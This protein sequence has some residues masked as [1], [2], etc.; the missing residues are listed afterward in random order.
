MTSSRGGYVNE[1]EE[2]KGRVGGHGTKKGNA[3]CATLSGYAIITSRDTRP[4]APRGINQNWTF[5]GESDR[6]IFFFLR[7][8]RLLSRYLDRSFCG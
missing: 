4:L 5:L 7:R 3:V 6:I 1:V 2:V 8:L